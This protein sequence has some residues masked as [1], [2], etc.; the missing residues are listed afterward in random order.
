[1]VYHYGGY[2]I[3]FIFHHYAPKITSLWENTRAC[4]ELFLDRRDRLLLDTWG[5]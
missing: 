5:V 2:G 3:P 4:S 1:M